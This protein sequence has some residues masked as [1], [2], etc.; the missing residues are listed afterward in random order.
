MNEKEIQKLQII[1][2]H[3]QKDKVNQKN[4]LGTFMD[5]RDIVEPYL[6]ISMEDYRLLCRMSKHYDS[7]T[8]AVEDIPVI[9][10]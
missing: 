7:L 4:V 2:N 8:M 3:I 6:R 9:N 10:N 5:G 1:V